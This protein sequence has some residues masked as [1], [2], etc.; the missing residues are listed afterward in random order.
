M[1]QVLKSR[2]FYNLLTGRTPQAFNLSLN[3]N[4][5]ENN[6]DLTREQWSILA[7]LW[8]EDGK[9]QQFL[10]D[11]SYRDRPSVTRLIDNLERMKLVERQADPNDRRSKLIFLT[12]KG[13]NME[14]KVKKVVEKT[15]DQAIQNIDI[16]EIEFMK[17]IFDKIYNNLE[18]K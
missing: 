10:A 14:E 9:S 6:V 4:F 1:Q 15:V 8:E 11:K 12:T 2:D 13:K 3:K 5:R 16:S 17:T 7:L 18:N